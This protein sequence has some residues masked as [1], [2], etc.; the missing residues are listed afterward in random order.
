MLDKLELK[1]IESELSPISPFLE[2]RLNHLVDG[3]PCSQRQLCKLM[4]NKIHYSHLSSLEHGRTPSLNELKSY[5]DYFGVSYEYL[6]GEEKSTTVKN[7][8]FHHFIT[9]FGASHNKDERKMWDTFV[10]ITTTEDGLALLY[11]ISQYLYQK[12][13]RTGTMSSE[14]FVHILNAWKDIPDKGTLSYQNV[15]QLLDNL[16][17]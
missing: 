5:H 15:R 6:L 17:T 3:K 4:D 13:K 2:L 14:E 9:S 12:E 7:N 16:L 1:P 10:K 8:S 11:Y